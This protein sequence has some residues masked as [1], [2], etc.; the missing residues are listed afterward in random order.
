[1]KTTKTKINDE[2]D[3]TI[4]IQKVLEINKYIENYYIEVD[5][6]EYKNIPKFVEIVLDRY[7]HILKYKRKC[8]VPSHMVKD[9][10]NSLEKLKNYIIKKKKMKKLKSKS[11]GKMN[12]EIHQTIG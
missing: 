1:M 5:F 12:I 9:L 3:E 2:E 8:S 11:L 6:Q 10:F 4:V 7:N